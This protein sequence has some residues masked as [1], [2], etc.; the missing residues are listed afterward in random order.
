MHLILELLPAE[1]EEIQ[2]SKFLNHLSSPIKKYSFRNQI[3]FGSFPIVH[4]SVLRRQK[5]FNYKPLYLTNKVA[6]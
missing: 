4:I 1:K 5:V 6:F 2:S 3:D